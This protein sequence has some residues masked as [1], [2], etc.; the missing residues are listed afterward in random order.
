MVYD[1][2]SNYE[3]YASL[4]DDI[5]I[6]LEF[7]LHATPATENGVHELSPRVKA[8]V[9]E[10]TTKPQNENGYEAHCQYID[11]QYLISG[12]EKVACL[13]LEY[14]KETK[15]YSED[16]DAAFYEQSDVQPQELLIGNGYFAILF[17]QDGHMPQLSVAAPLAVKKVVVKV[18]TPNP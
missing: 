18:A 5:R 3:T 4:S 17:P 2:I 15:P 8:I 12:S 14:L 6:G 11:I 1:K 16:I 10:Y 13:P 9:S 7:L